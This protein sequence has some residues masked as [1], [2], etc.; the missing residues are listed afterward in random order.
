MFDHVQEERLDGWVEEYETLI[1]LQ[2]GFRKGRRLDDYLFCLT[3]CISV[4]TREC[5]GLLCSYLDMAKPYD[6]VPHALLLICLEE[7]AVLTELALTI[8][9]LYTEGKISARFGAVQ[10]A[11]V[12]VGRGIK[13]GCLPLTASIHGVCGIGR[14]P[15]A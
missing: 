14:T 6:N 7:V 1:E 10:S 15:I 9:R 8:Q 4:A 12:I 11:D 3:Q 13:Q 5:Q 2:S